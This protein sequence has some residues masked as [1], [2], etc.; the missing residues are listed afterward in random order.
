MQNFDVEKW[1]LECIETINHIF[2]LLKK[3]SQ[4]INS[5]NKSLKNFID[6]YKIAQMHLL[7]CK[8]YES[9]AKNYEMKKV[10][11]KYFRELGLIKINLNGQYLN[12]LIQFKKLQFDLAVISFNEKII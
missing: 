11:S 3:L 9:F 6:M 12:K 8:F 2:F 7:L 5:R 4:E 10:V 1:Q